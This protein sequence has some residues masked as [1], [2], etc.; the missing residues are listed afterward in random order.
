MRYPDTAA[1]WSSTGYAQL[2]RSRVQVI[3]GAATLCRTGGGPVTS[4]QAGSGFQSLDEKWQGPWP[5]GF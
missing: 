1:R 5:C 4:R 3:A 2:A